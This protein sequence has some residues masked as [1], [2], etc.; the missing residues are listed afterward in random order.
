MAE[1]LA[2]PLFKNIWFNMSHNI[3]SMTHHSILNTLRVLANSDLEV[4]ENV[5]EHLPTFESVI[6]ENYTRFLSLDIAT[7]ISSFLKLNYIPSDIINELNKQTIFS[8]LNKHSIILMLESLTQAKY[9]ENFEFY[10]KLISQ[11]KKSSTNLSS[12]LCV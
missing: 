3:K 2:A 7:V 6:M 12:G 10:E 8:T 5:R 1:Q 4:T 11:F 9:N